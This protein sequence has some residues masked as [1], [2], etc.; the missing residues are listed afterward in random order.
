MTELLQEL[1]RELA[2]LPA[3]KQ[4]RWVSHFLKELSSETRVVNGDNEDNAKGE[5]IGGRRPSQEE[6]TEAMRK[7]Q[8]L[9]RGIT[10]GD[11][12]GIKELINEG[13]R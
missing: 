6:V 12:I 5:W 2:K 8:E 1:E 3:E 7:L 13:R 11:D 4:D 10:L 9:R